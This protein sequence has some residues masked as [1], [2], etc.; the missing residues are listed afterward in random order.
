MSVLRRSWLYFLCLK[1]EQARCIDYC[2]SV[3]FDVVFVRPLSVSDRW[4]CRAALALADG[5]LI[6][7]RCQCARA[8]MK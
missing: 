5:V 4:G 7:Q 8:A 1:D 6:P 2:T 3:W